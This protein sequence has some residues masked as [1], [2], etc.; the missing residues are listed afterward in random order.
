M[1]VTL[2]APKYFFPTPLSLLGVHV[3][4]LEDRGLKSQKARLLADSFFLLFCRLWPSR[5]LLAHPAE[6]RDGRGVQH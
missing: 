6:P 5:Y 4:G 3:N 2:P 1:Q